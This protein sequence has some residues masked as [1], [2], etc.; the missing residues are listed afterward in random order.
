MRL[1]FP[2]YTK[3]VLWFFL[4]LL[5]LVAVLYG[6][7]RMQFRLGMESLLSG[8]AGARVQSVCQSIAAELGVSSG[9][10]W[11]PVLQRF[12]DAYRVQFAVFRPEATQVAGPPV[13]LPIVVRNRIL[14]LPRRTDI[15]AATAGTDTF[16]PMLE[17]GL[18]PKFMVRT[19]RPDFYW[20]GTKLPVLEPGRRLPSSMI[21]LAWSASVRGGGLFFDP[22]PWIIVGC[23][24]LILC[25]IFWFPLARS[26]THSISQMTNVTERIAQGRFEARVGA[27]RRDELGRLGHAINQMAARLEGFVT[28]QKRF[29]G[30]VAHELCSPLARIQVALGILEQNSTLVGTDSL[31]D[32]RDDVQHMSRLVHDLLSFSKAALEPQGAKLGPVLLADSVEQAVEREAGADS[33]L[34]IRIPAGLAVMADADL[35]ARSIGNLVR[36]ALRYAAQPGPITISASHSGEWVDLVFADCGPGV[37]EDALTK[38]FDPFYRPEGSRNAATGG[39]GLGL[40]IVKT[41]V[42]SCQG[43]VSCRNR[44]PSGLEV[45]LRLRFAPT[46]KQASLISVE[47]R[48]ES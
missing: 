38:L 18:I 45:T 36:N 39:V 21:I 19:S 47:A 9:E 48:T 23:S 31:H 41:C 15:A 13:S 32:L 26:L 43:T 28:G 16:G 42:E 44:V 34:D 29:L 11:D 2:L 10:D 17:A 12:S 37:P 6:A 24:V 14:T 33:A 22:T 35:L 7:L 3:I 40:A 27:K 30:D 20:V 25:V 1:P 4:N 8:R 46:P 5:C